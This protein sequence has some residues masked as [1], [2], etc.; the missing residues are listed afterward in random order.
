[1]L[2]SRKGIPIGNLTS[3]LFAN[4]YLNELDKFVKHELKAKYYVRYCDDFVILS[5][6]SADLEDSIPKIQ[7]FLDSKLKLRLHENKITI[8]KLRQGIDFLG[9]VTLPNCIVLRTKTR[10]RMIR[11]VNS[12]NLSSYLGLLKHCKGYELS[13]LVRNKIIR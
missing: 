3:Q 9:Y 1:L 12:K 2:F 4:I 13:N 6:T 8:R 10:K 11:K 7:D 5:Q